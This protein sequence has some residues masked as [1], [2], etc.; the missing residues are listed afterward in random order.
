MTEQD[1]GK[2]A[3]SLTA[4][5]R[6]T[7]PNVLRPGTCALAQGFPSRHNVSDGFGRVNVPNSSVAA[8][9]GTAVSATAIEKRA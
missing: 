6:V 4:G 5:R 8:L 3:P 2:T 7:H 9:L 1:V